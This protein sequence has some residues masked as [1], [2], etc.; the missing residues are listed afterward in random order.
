MHDKRFNVVVVLFGGGWFAQRDV[1]ADQFSCLL[2]QQA[3]VVTDLSCNLFVCLLLQPRES[4]VGD[5]LLTRYGTVRTDWRPQ[6]STHTHTSTIPYIARHVGGCIP[7]SAHHVGGSVPIIAH[8]FPLPIEMDR[9]EPEERGQLP[10]AV[11]EE[12]KGAHVYG[13]GGVSPTAVARRL[14]RRDQFVTH[15]TS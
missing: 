13:S 12:D 6:V 1:C 7:I 15:C 14:L 3:P 2:T 9:A 8:Q 5:T 4:S 10:Q 11:P